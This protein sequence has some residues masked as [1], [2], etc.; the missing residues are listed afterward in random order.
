LGSATAAPVGPIGQAPLDL[1]Q[2]APARD[3]APPRRRSAR[4]GA[5]T[6]Q[7]NRAR[8]LAGVNDGETALHELAAA[9]TPGVLLGHELY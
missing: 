4:A 6:A 9:Q 1:G 2:T 5:L 7:R 8:V 3:L